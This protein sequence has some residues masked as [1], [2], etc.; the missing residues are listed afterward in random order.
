MKTKSFPNGLLG[1]GVRLICLASVTVG[2][3]RV[4]AT[5]SPIAP[6]S[7]R[8]TPSDIVY[9]GAFRLPDV[10]Q[11]SSWEY[12]G[13]A[14]TYCPSGDPRG[15]ADGHPGSLFAVG[16]DHQQMISE[17]SIPRPVISKS[18]SKSK[19]QTLDELPVAKTLQPFR[20]VRGDFYGELEIPRAGLAYL[21][22]QPP[23]RTGKLHF[24]WGQHFEFERRPTHGWCELDLSKPQAAGPWYLAHYSAHVSNDYLFEIPESWAAANTPGLRLAT[25]RFRDGTWGGLG[26]ALL[27]YGPWNEGNPPKRGATLTRVTPLLMYGTPID[28]TAELD[29]SS[30]HKL[31]GFSEADEWSGGAWLTAGNRSAVVLVGT[32]G[33]G[34]TWYGFAN[35]VVY[36]TSGDENE[37]YPDVPPA[38]FDQRGWWSERI[39]AQM[40]FYDPADLADVAHKKRQPWEPQPFATRSLDPYLFDPGFNHERQK[41]YL[42]G[43]VA[44]DRERG[45]LYLVERRADGEKSLI[46]VFSVTP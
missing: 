12:S 37:T 44:F 8:L 3:D 1:L 11:D 16:H 22:A 13:N 14:M 29:V 36:P 30:G 38:P 46:H 32:K 39:E 18:K 2:D 41:R 7:A 45:L 31:R 26:P 23:Q 28:D 40:I 21:P 6:S 34:K 17:L 27:A 35:G 19:S 20:D 15:P 25:G 10:E 42:L 5:V 4:G 43:D 24:A 33:L 9:R